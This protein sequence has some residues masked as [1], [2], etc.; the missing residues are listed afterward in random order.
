MR[1]LFRMFAGFAT[2]AVVLGCSS[3][4]DES[5]A[6][7]E[8]PLLFVR[9]PIFPVLPIL[10]PIEGQLGGACLAPT[11]SDPIQHCDNGLGCAIYGGLTCEACGGEG[12]TCCDG[13]STAFGGFCPVPP[14]ASGSM[15]CGICQNG[16]G[17]FFAHTCQ[18]CGTTNGG[19][20]CPPD[21]GNV[22]YFCFGSLACSPDHS[23]CESCGEPNEPTCDAPQAC[24]PATAAPVAGGMCVACGVQNNPRCA[25]GAPCSPGLVANA[26]GIC[27]PASLVEVCAFTNNLGEDGWFF[28]YDVVFTFWSNGAYAAAGSVVDHFPQGDGVDIG[29][30]LTATWQAPGVNI[31]VTTNATDTAPTQVNQSGTSASIETNWATLAS[32]HCTYGAV[33]LPGQ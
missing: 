32:G 24:D 8:D 6:T 10:G 27:E 14:T 29:E 9:V 4:P 5:T 23:H 33:E 7:S 28:S 16:T 21:R 2:S 18:I 12:Q 22:G 19:A 26:A 1:A 11:A 20:C 31:A 13:P 17:C 25:S 30:A 3:A 15:D